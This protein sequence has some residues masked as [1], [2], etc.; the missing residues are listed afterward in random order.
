MK[1]SENAKRLKRPVDVAG[2]LVKTN[3]SRP[4]FYKCF[5]KDSN[6]TQA[7]C[8]DGHWKPSDKY[9]LYR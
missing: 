8:D 6:W 9:Q 7:V 1:L 2:G 4:L 5:K 3:S